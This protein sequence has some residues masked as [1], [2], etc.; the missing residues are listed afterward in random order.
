MRLLLLLI[1]LLLPG[2]LLAQSF[3][4]LI[5]LGD[6]TKAE[7]LLKEQDSGNWKSQKSKA[8][9]LTNSA[10]L[11]LNKGRQDLALEKL[12]EA[13]ALFQQSKT[14]N[15]KEAANCLS[16]LSLTYTA[17]GKYNQA[18]ENGAIALQMRQ[19]LFGEQS[20][21]VAA[22]YNDL[23]LAY[24]QIDPDKALESYEKA[25]AVYKK[26]HGNE[27]PKI[28]I[29]NTNIGGL[30]RQIE[31]Y[32]DAINNLEAAS[33]IWLKLYPDG[34]PSLGFVYRSLGQTYVK[35]E[36]NQLALTYFEKALEQYRKSFGEKHP[37]IASTLNQI[38]AVHINQQLFNNALD[39]F[40]QAMCA[41]IPSFNNKDISINPPI[42]EFYNANVLLY[43]LMFKAQGLEAKHFGKTLKLSDL[44]LAL[45]SL[46][47]CDSLIDDIRHHSSN[48]SDK[49]SLGTLAND[50]YEDGVRL[51]STISEITATPGKYNEIAFYFAEKSKSAVLQESIADSQAKSF[52]GIPQDLVDQEKNLKSGIAFL[53]QRLSLAPPP[54]E[55]K[56]L[57]ESLFVLNNEYTAFTK[58]LEKDYP[59]YFNLKFNNSFPTVA[60]LQAMLGPDEAIYSYFVAEKAKKMFQFEITSKK[61]KAYEKTLPDDFDRLMKG[62]INGIYYRDFETFQRS[63]NKL[64]YV[65]W[66]ETKKKKV[67]VIPS[68]RMSTLPL[69]ALPVQAK[70]G[71][72]FSSITYLVQNKSISYEFSVGL[73]SQKRKQRSSHENQSIFLCAPVKFPEKDNLNELPGTESEIK[74]IAGLFPT[75][76][77]EVMLF[78][79]ANEGIVKSNDITR[80]NYLHFA[81]HGVVDEADPELSRIFLSENSGEDGH[82]FSGEIYNLK[83]NADLAVLSACQTG[84]GKYSKGEGVIGLSRAL[85]YAGARNLIV[86]FWSVADESTAVLMTDFYS[87][88]LKDPRGFA[89]ALQQSKIKMINS[90]KFV[91]PYYWAPFVLIGF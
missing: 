19:Q 65:L 45:S 76:S 49:L 54:D 16:W 58:K 68:G 31:L 6:Y 25:L 28:A 69:E 57:R 5:A 75:A 64:K 53:A 29:A 32:G 38:G 10:T 66:P 9:Y 1:F 39:D 81:T 17:S 80:Y 18:E 21:E 35:M 42:N 13:Y 86:S 73:F 50:V 88:L 8:V 4:E 7:A 61:F 23:G 78:D 41:N 85:V 46:Y 90:K 72:N 44:K 74:T 40:Q 62:M 2:A 20:E 82:L 63:S 3:D 33:K 30:Y 87:E 11:D 59:N 12:N 91:E 55:E 51:A 70:A 48:E 79:K 36:N 26:L 84:L 67:V 43:S 77:K 71:D 52:A 60:E 22:S 37:D 34:H 83:L 14:A 56:Y 24:S 47:L 15:T 27:H 89:P